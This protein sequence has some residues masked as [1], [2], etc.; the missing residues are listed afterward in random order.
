MIV[1]I[2]A[3]WSEN[4]GD[5]KADIKQSFL[6]AITAIKTGKNRHYIRSLKPHNLISFYRQASSLTG[7]CSIAIRGL[8]VRVRFGVDT[9][10]N[11]RRERRQKRL[12]KPSNS[13]R[14]H[15]R[16]L[17]GITPLIYTSQ[18]LTVLYNRPILRSLL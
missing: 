13:A 8:H 9:S 11:N 7:P 15:I 12:F 1:L 14:I 4:F 16:M 6:T 18:I 5:S 2:V 10:S 3:N 17:H